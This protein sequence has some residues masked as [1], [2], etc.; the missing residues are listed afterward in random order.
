MEHS[1]V[2]TVDLMRGICPRWITVALG[3]G[4]LAAKR[5]TASVNMGTNGGPDQ[6]PKRR[7]IAGFTEITKFG[8]RPIATMSRAGGIPSIE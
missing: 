7:Q 4:T 3:S 5:L 6:K 2:Q 8:Y 1:A